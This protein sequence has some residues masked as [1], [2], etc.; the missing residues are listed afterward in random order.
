MDWNP[1]I[2]WREDLA[3]HRPDVLAESVERKLTE[4]AFF[5]QWRKQYLEYPDNY[6]F[7]VNTNTFAFI[8]LSDS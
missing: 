1:R 4:R 6:T 2:Y 3:E 7:T 5:E 8:S